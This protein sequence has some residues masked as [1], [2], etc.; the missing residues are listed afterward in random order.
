MRATIAHDKAKSLF[1]NCFLEMDHAHIDAAMSNFPMM[2]IFVKLPPKQQIMNKKKKKAP[3]KRSIFDGKDTD[4]HCLCAVNYF[5]HEQHT[6]VLWL[7]ST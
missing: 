6:V 7:A 2:G 3:D 1:H 5:R 4:V